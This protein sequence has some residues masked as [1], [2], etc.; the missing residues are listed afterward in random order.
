MS[1]EVILHDEIVEMLSVMVEEKD[2]YTFGHSKRV[3]TYSAKIAKALCLSQEE[4]D[5]MYQASLLHD[6]GKILTP[7]AVLLKPRKFNRQEYD[8]IKKHPMDGARMVAFISP[9]KAYADII[10][11]HHEHYD[12]SGYPDGLKAEE[13]PLL[14]RIMSIA[15]AFDAMTTNRIY[16][17]RKNIQQAIDELRRCSGKQFDPYLVDVAIQTLSSL[18][19]L[20]TFSQS[21]KDAIQEARFSYFFKDSL[22]S[23]YSGEYLNYF[24]LHNKETQQFQCCYFIQTRQMQ[25]Y[26]K[27]YGWKMGDHALVEIALRLKVLFHTSYIFRI[28]GDDFVVLSPS[29]MS[30]DEKEIVYKLSCGFDGLSICLEHFDLNNLPIL[31]WENLEKYSVSTYKI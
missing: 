17:A 3:A 12:G 18:S 23:A 13:I 8:I 9:F 25:V 7:E 24:L 26:N 10:A 16:K 1:H 2:T 19:E 11:H 21:P 5:I 14:S 20:V 6:I 30:I 28:F 31:K 22:T 27:K 15:D 4:Q 29:H